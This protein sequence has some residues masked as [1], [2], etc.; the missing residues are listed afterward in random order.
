YSRIFPEAFFSQE[1]KVQGLK[2]VWLRLRCSRTCR[3]L[4]DHGYTVLEA[5][6][7]E[8]A[9]R[10]VRQKPAG[11]I[12][13]LL[14]DVI[15]PQMSGKDLAERV[16]KARSDIKV[17]FVSGYTD[18]ALR[19]KGVPQSDAVLLQKPFTSSALA[20]KVREALDS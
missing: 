12:H 11:T 20:R 1:S 10:I 7:G 14:S 19:R 6:N 4:R 3:I 2:S 8:E 18:T 17:L 5:A 13:L 15:M 9:L 16:K